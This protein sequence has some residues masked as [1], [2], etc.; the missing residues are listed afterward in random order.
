M[1]RALQIRHTRKTPSPDPL[2]AEF[3]EPAV[4]E[5]EPRGTRRRVVQMK[6]RM[7]LQPAPH[8]L[9]LVGPIIVRDQMQVQP[10]RRVPIRGFQAVLIFSSSRRSTSGISKS[11]VRLRLS[12]RD[13]PHSID[14]WSSGWRCCSPNG[15][16]GE[17]AGTA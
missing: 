3:T 11:S 10:G 16:E 9:V 2:L 17:A 14:T 4:G 13:S 12:T 7:S 15:L 1:D 5:I 6:Q 8:R